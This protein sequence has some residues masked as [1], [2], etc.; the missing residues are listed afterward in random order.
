[1]LYTL[2]CIVDQS[3]ED[4]WPKSI[5]FF[6]LYMKCF[7]ALTFY[8]QVNKNGIAIERKIIKICK[9]VTKKNWISMPKK[10]IKISKI[11]ET[12]SLEYKFCF[13]PEICA[14]FNLLFM[15]LSPCL[16]PIQY[17]RILSQ[18]VLYSC[19]FLIRS[20]FQYYTHK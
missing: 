17:Y 16:I 3:V 10:K 15:F 2:K 19:V 20:S 6:I 18:S 11:N 8:E 1:M 14:A 4:T 9:V 13:R 5:L 12:K 7:I